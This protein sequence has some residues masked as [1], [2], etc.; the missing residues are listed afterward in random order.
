[1]HLL[2]L[3]INFTYLVNAWNTEHVI[4]YRDIEDLRLWRVVFAIITASRNTPYR[5]DLSSP[6]QKLPND[7]YFKFRTL[8]FQL[9]GFWKVFKQITTSAMLFEVHPVST[10]ATVFELTTH[11][12]LKL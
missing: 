4:S 7:K 8:L 10:L 3:L 9:D 1:M 11:I 12:S 5:A 6:T 2:A